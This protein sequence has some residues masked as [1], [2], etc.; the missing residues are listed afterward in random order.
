MSSFHGNGVQ[1]LNSFGLSLLPSPK[2]DLPN[3]KGSFRYGYFNSSYFNEYPPNDEL[4]NDSLLVFYHPSRRELNAQVKSKLQSLLELPLETTHYVDYLLNPGNRI[5]LSHPVTVR[6][7]SLLLCVDY[8]GSHSPEFL[9]TDSKGGSS[10][11]SLGKGDA[12]IFD[13][14]AYSLESM[15]SKEQDSDKGSNVSGSFTH[16]IG[17]NYVNMDGHYLE[18]AFGAV[19]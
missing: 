9:L 5:Y 19:G 3:H 18:F 13:G 1:L 14:M 16:L 4:L 17:F 8:D 12:L 6:E 10:R 2:E 7:F 15:T 11:V